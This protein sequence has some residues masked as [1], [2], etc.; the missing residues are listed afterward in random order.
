MR[1]N[2]RLSSLCTGIPED[3]P[4]NRH[5]QQGYPWGAGRALRTPICRSCPCVS[6][7]CPAHDSSQQ[8]HS[9][10]GLSWQPEWECLHTLKN[11]V[12][13]W[14]APGKPYTAK[15]HHRDKELKAIPQFSDFSSKVWQRADRM[16]HPHSIKLRA[17]AQALKEMSSQLLSAVRWTCHNQLPARG[18]HCQLESY[19][20][21]SKTRPPSPGSS[22]PALESC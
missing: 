10:H 3:Q 2:T 18:R 14:P 16:Q 5:A 6:H 17:T 15:D 19:C 12:M 21:G 13:H 9:K 22:A 7:G 8:L 4:R 1:L 11:E 20:V